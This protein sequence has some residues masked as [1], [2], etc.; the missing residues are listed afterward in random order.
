MIIRSI[1]IE[2]FR[3]FECASFA[4]GKRL[5]A[6]SGRNATQKTTVLGMLGQP[7]TI[8]K[9]HSMYG[10]KT[11]DGYNFRSQ[12]KEKFKI[13]PEHD[14]IGEHKWK[15]VLHN[16]VY[17]QNYYRVESIARR[18]RDQE[19]TLRFWNAESRASGAGYI[20]LP[21]YFLSL[22]R[23]FPIGES[24]KTQT[25]SPTLTPDELDYCITN[26]RT[27][28][29]IQSIPGQPFV[30]LELEK[31]S[32]S[33]TFSGVSDGVHDIFT[34]S[35]GE[36]NIT[37]I[38]LAVL[39]FKRL[40]EQYG[41]NYKGGILLIDELDATLYGFSQRKLVD[42]LWKSAEDYKIQ[43]VFTTHSPFILKQVNKYQRKERKEKG[44]TLPLFAY[45]SSIVYLE[46]QYDGEGTRTIMPKNISTT[47][48]L[49]SIL[50]DI[51]LVGPNTGSKINVYCEDMLAVS[52]TQYVLSDALGINLDLY[53]NFVD[54]NLGWTNY[55]QLY[56][57]NVPE[58][59][60]NIIILDGDVPQKS[61]YRSKAQVVFAADNFLFLPLVIEKG[62]FETL[63]N[64]DAFNRF[65]DSY[66][67]VPAFTYDLCFNEWPLETERYSTDD[68]KHWFVKAEEILGDQDALFSF[69][70]NEHHEAVETFVEHFVRAFNLLA[71][72]KEVDALPPIDPPENNENDNEDN[73]ETE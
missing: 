55:V 41:R 67:K 63:K 32:S 23:L 43:I 60:N 52:F 57:K 53:M 20:Q 44:I 29:S 30:G 22:S 70:C 27:I 47:S 25:F 37:R 72:R 34:N 3:A 68:Y 11:I 40:Q 24:G 4:L 66:S 50:N 5:T 15:L 59:K 8:S 10:C 65:H 38:L 45:D 19:P 36:G 69:W 64:H 54:I 35:A 42:Y 13:S 26:Y 31:G 7:F 51:N 62:L 17:S 9:D 2:K 33:K 1:E 73:N 14:I 58:F 61:E 56:E 18:Q 48:E 71:E 49:N 46:P 12:F 16:G 28:L 6:I 39:S 21:V